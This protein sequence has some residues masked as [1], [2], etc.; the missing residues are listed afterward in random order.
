MRYVDIEAICLLFS[1]AGIFFLVFE[2][3]KKTLFFVAIAIIGSYVVLYITTYVP[4]SNDLCVLNFT[5]YK[6]EESHD[7][8]DKLSLWFLLLYRFFFWLFSGC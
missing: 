5:E 7:L 2:K 3:T 6:H 8:S 1:I 4:V